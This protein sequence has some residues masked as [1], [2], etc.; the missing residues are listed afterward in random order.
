MIERTGDMIK[1]TRADGQVK[2]FHRSKN[3]AAYRWIRRGQANL[4]HK[5]DD[6]NLTSYEAIADYMGITSRRVRQIEAQAIVK[7]KKALEMDRLFME[8]AE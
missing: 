5:C 1:A 2:M 8:L 7:L 3:R 4:V 6:H